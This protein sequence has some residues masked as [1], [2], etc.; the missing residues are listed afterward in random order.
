LGAKAVGNLLELDHKLSRWYQ[1]LPIHLRH[2]PD[3][4]EAAIHERHRNVLYIRY[5]R[6]DEART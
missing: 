3:S 2:G 5:S 4:V 6:N 1:E